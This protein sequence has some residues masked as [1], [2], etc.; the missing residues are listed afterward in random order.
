MPYW[1][2][3][4]ST[5]SLF[6]LRSGICSRTLVPRGQ[7]PGELLQ[8]LAGLDA[9]FVVHVLKVFRAFAA[10]GGRLAMIDSDIF[11]ATA[12]LGGAGEFV[13]LGFLGLEEPAVAQLV[14]AA[15][16]GSDLV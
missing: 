3:A 12:S 16:E 2:F 4:N 10:G 14:L 9:L 11:Q 6:C 13:G 15:V 8:A 1:Y 7:D 5:Q